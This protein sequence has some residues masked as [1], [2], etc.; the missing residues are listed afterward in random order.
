MALENQMNPDRE[1]KLRALFVS[2]CRRSFD[3][4]MQRSTGGNL[5]LRFPGDRLL[6]KP[7]GFS[8]YELTP[9]DL[10]VCSEQGDVLQ[11]RGKPTKELGSHLAIYAARPDVGGIVHYHPPYATAFAV[12]GRALPLLTVHAARKLGR[13]PLVDPPGE[14]SPELARALAATFADT[15]VK[16]ALLAQHG[17]IA[18]GKDLIQAQNLAE[19][20]EESAQ[21]AWL[22]HGLRDAPDPP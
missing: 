11:G 8:L 7:S 6:V 2:I 15:G 14:G 3:L 22:A 12:S 5:S 18:A 1:A 20:V 10:L 4:G 9:E 13:V 19:L 16:A 21:V 17:L